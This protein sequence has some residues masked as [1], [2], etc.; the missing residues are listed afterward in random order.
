MLRGTAFIGHAMFLVS[1]AITLAVALSYKWW[2]K[3]S[4]RRSPLQFKK[5]GNL[6]GQQ[7]L[8]RID[9]HRDELGFGLDLM[10]IALP[11]LFLVWATMNIDWT[12][13]GFGAGEATF[14]VGWVGFFSLGFWCYRRHYRKHE[15]AKDG[16][17][18]ERVT[19]MQLNRLMSQ[20]CTVMHDLPCDGFNIDHI[21][22]AP[23]GV[24]AVETKSFRKPRDLPGGKPAKATFDGVGLGFGDFATR[25]PIEQSRRQA[26]W[27]ARYLREAM[28]EQVAV[29]PAVSL[30]GWFV[31]K[32]EDGRKSDVFVF[33]PMGRGCEWFTYGAEVLPASKRA[34]IAQALA[35]RYP[36]LEG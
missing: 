33:T 31:E 14:V 15:Q 10:I 36:E 35:L 17:L 1:V 2:H 22:I 8:Q 19:G 11:M 21:V 30:P 3:R 32:T 4:Q 26:Q 20:G 24:F 28:Q 34:V 16:L 27:L 6:P 18:A 29:M 12:K 5:I 23:R 13:V 7:L 9:K 25:E